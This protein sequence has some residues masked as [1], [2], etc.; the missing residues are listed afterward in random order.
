VDKWLK[1]KVSRC[2]LVLSEKEMTSLLSHDPDLWKTAVGRG[3]GFTR[4]TQ[5]RERVAKK[6]QA[7][8]NNNEHI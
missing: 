4:S 8:T 5:T 1:F 3:K 6:V 2:L 7:E